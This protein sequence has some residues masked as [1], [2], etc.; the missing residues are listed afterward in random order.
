MEGKNKEILFF[1]SGSTVALFSIQ[2]CWNTRKF[3]YFQKRCVL[4]TLYFSVNRENVDIWNH[5]ARTAI[6]RHFDSE[7]QLVEKQKQESNPSDWFVLKIEI[8]C[9]AVFALRSWIKLRPKSVHISIG[10]YSLNENIN[11]EIPL[12]HF[13]C[14]E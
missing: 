10:K 3:A 13:I 6:K 4:I 11:L 8:S 14:R 7:D 1:K 2:S 12:E 5:K 9:T